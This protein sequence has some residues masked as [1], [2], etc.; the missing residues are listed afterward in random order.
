MRLF[1]SPYSCFLDH[2]NSLSLTLEQCSKS[3]ILLFKQFAALLLPCLSEDSDDEY[4][5]SFSL[6]QIHMLSLQNHKSCSKCCSSLGVMCYFTWN[7]FCLL[8]NCG[9]TQ[10][11]NIMTKQC[12]CFSCRARSWPIYLTFWFSV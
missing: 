12:I 11:S 4:E 3:F 2:G 5:K 9:Y 7:L 10:R 6:P 8:C 1:S